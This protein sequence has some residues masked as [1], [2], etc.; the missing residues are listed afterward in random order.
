MILTF[1]FL[2]C[3]FALYYFKWSFGQF[4][5]QKCL[6]LLFLLVGFVFLFQLAVN[7]A[8][9][10]FPDWPVCPHAQTFQV[11]TRIVSTTDHKTILNN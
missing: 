2:S 11:C 8:L 1:H 3:L 6:L 7:A 10:L 9:F 5:I 4:A